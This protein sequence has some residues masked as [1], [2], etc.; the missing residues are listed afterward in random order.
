M[1]T[2][3]D[4][5]R[6]QLLFALRQHNVAG[7]RIGEAIAEV[8][9]HIAETG[10]D[11]VAAFG[12]PAEYARRLAGSLAPRPGTEPRPAGRWTTILVGLVAF[13]AAAFAATGMLRDSTVMTVAGLVL[14]AALV[15][16]LA[17]RRPVNR[18]VDPRTG[19]TMRVPA[20]RGALLVLAVCLLVLAVLAALVR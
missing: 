9:S 4:T 17:R 11:P 5:Y 8:E 13:A 3:L 12:E 7:A 18:V 19:T 16:W 15:L 6:Q 10:E 20:P 1:S 2:N 14:L